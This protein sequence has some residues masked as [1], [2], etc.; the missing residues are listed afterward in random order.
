[1]LM[2]QLHLYY[3]GPD[4]AYLLQA[5]HAI[6]DGDS[7]KASDILTTDTNILQNSSHIVICDESV[8]SIIGVDVQKEYA[9]CW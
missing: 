5:V 3:T 6:V 9:K 1:M 2:L 7:Q 4:G 8:K